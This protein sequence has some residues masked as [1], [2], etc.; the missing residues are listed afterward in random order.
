MKKPN[1]SLKSD[2]LLVP[3]DN[4]DNQ[5]QEALPLPDLIWKRAF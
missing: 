4:R 3:G 5:S 2:G 1:K